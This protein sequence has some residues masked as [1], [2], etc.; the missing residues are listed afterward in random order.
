[1]VLRSSIARIRAPASGNGTTD[2]VVFGCDLNGNGV[3]NE[4]T[5]GEWVAMSYLTWMDLCAYADWADY[6]L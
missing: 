4:A 6:G 3:L 2:P 5:D 1:M